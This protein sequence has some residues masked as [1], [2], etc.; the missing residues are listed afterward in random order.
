MDT[1]WGTSSVFIAVHP[2][3]AQPTAARAAPRSHRSQELTSSGLSPSIGPRALPRELR[4]VR[5]VIRRPI[6]TGLV[7]RGDE[8]QAIEIHRDAEAGPVIGIQL[9]LLERQELVQIR[10]GL[11]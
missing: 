3:V 7:D 6:G 4:A 11:G 9:A 5:P 1:N 10:D 2:V 8:A